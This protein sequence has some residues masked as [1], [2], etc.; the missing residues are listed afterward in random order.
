MIVIRTHKQQPVMELI[1]RLKHCCEERESG[2]VRRAG[3]TPAE[4]ACL[5]ALPGD[6]KVAAG[7]VATRMRLSPSRGSRV[8]DA[9]VRRGL[10][11]RTTSTRDRRSIDL[12]L[13][14][15]GRAVRRTI[16]AALTSCDRQIRSRLKATE[17]ARAAGGLRLLLRAL[18]E[19]T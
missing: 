2:I 14:N 1:I 7:L 17:L 8:V 16:D 10:V 18:E 9:L 4:Y 3:L 15:G 19:E 13:S 11:L 12:S 6:G 5:R